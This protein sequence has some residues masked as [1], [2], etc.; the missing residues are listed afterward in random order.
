MNIYEKLD[1]FCL[2]VE[3]GHELIKDPDN[4]PNIFFY[5]LDKQE[6]ME[7]ER[8]MK[9]G[10]PRELREYYQRLG[11]GYMQ[12]PPFDP[13]EWSNDKWINFWNNILAPSDVAKLYIG[14][15]ESSAYFKRRDFDWCEFKKNKEFPF[16]QFD[17]ADFIVYK[18]NGTGLYCFDTKVA[19]TIAQF[20]ERLCENPHF[21]VEMDR[22]HEK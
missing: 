8:V 2:T 16:M 14:K 17:E 12:Y 20:F 6:V 3:N 15:H 5:P 10:F 13:K 21:Y 19:D 1:K 11:T 22:L 7:A 9:I 4:F 18:R